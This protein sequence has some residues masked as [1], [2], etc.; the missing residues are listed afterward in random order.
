MAVR[1]G[2]SVAR[3]QSKSRGGEGGAMTHRKPPTNATDINEANSQFWNRE[4]E[5]IERLVAKYPDAYVRAV[6]HAMALEP[7]LQNLSAQIGVIDDDK[8]QIAMTALLKATAAADVHAQMRAVEPR[9]EREK[10]QVRERAN[11]SRKAIGETR[12]LNHFRAW[13]KRGT[14]ALRGMDLAEQVTAYCRTAQ[15]PYFSDPDDLR[16][17]NAHEK[18]RIRGLLKD[19]RI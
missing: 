13:Q 18:K 1:L 14:G 8:R 4:T 7:A 2:K 17:L 19:G 11:N 12:I 3:S 10:A 6:D 15:I 9:R 16:N 5:E